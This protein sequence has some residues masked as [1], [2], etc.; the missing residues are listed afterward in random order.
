[1][2]VHVYLVLFR[3]R[4]HKIHHWLLSWYLCAKLRLWLLLFA[5][6]LV[7][8]S[9]RLITYVVLLKI[10]LIASLFGLVFVLKISIVEGVEVVVV[11]A[12]ELVVLVCL[13]VRSH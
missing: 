6:A 8:Q 4:F 2:L 3:I 12:L 1:M 9:R 11:R 10:L 13:W 7:Y 5:A